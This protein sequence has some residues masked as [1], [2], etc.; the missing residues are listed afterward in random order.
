MFKLDALYDPPATDEIMGYQAY[1]Y[2]LEKPSFTKSFDEPKLDNNVTRYIAYGGA[3]SAP[4]ENKAWYF[5]GL[6]ATDRG[7]IYYNS[8]KESATDISATLIS[9]D[10]SVQYEETWNN[11]SLPENIKGRAN[12]Q[13]TW[14]P[15]GEQGLLVVLGGVTY[16]EWAG[17]A[18]THKSGN[19]SASVSIESIIAASWT[20]IGQE[21]TDL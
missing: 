21:F 13:V 12:P 14:I 10:M 16:P 20:V 18:G 19:E 2:G 11:N 3:A 8:L 4:S 15:A 17:E 7:P 1:A 9:L 6:V 5:S